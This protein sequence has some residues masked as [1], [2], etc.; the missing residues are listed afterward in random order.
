MLQVSGPAI[1][2][3]LFRGRVLLRSRL[4]RHLRPP[5]AAPRRRKQRP[6][7]RKSLPH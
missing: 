7:A 6:P 2:A 4:A 5:A 3:K 1:K